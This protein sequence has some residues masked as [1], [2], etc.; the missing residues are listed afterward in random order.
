MSEEYTITITEQPEW[1]VIGGGITSFNKQHAG[2]EHAQRLCFVVKGPDQS[3]LGGV[4][5]IIYWDWLAVDLMWLPEALRGRG[6]GH[7]LL[8]AIEDEARRRGAKHVHLDTF[9]FQAPEFYQQHGYRV[10]GELKDFP[11]GYTRYYL[12]KEL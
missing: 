7:Q 11:Q 1:D 8:T 9:S 3:V 10:F 12:T 2:E 5:G 6:L 4:I